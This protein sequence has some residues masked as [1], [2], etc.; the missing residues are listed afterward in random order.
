[1]AQSDSDH[2]V[3]SLDR[4]RPRLRDD[5]RFHFQLA[6]KEPVYVIEDRANRGYH[7][8]G[9]PEYRFLKSLDGRKPAAQLIAESANA[10]GKDAISEQ[11]SENLLRWALDNHLLKSLS[12]SQSDRRI[13]HAEDQAVG[14][15]KK[16]PKLMRFF[17]VKIPMGSPERLIRPFTAVFSWV[18][19]PGAIILWLGLIGYG[20][21]LAAE[22]WTALTASGARALLPAN[23]LW[24]ILITLVLKVFHELAH[25]I[26]TQKFG[27]VVPEWGIQLIALVTPLTYVDATSSW[28]FPSRWKR[29]RVAAAGMYVELGIAVV[30]LH[31]WTRLDPGFLRELAFNTIVVA[32]F[33]TLIFNANPLMRF[34]GYY[35]L[36]DLLNLR[37]VGQR[38]QQAFAWF[39]RRVFL[40]A[41]NQSLPPGIRDRFF[42]YFFYGAAAWCWK[43]LITIGIIAIMTK[44]FHGTGM[45][46]VL[47]SLAI[48][49]AG[50]LTAVWGLFFSKEKSGKVNWPSAAIRI[51]IA[52]GLLAL[53]FFGIKINPSSPA[54]AVIEYPDKTIVRVETSGFLTAIHC[55]DGQRV[56]KGDHLA[57]LEN[58]EEEVQLAKLTTELEHARARADSYFA[59]DRIGEWQT[60]KEVIRGLE[61]KSATLRQRIAAL[62]VVAPVSGVIHAPQ[63]SESEGHFASTGDPILTI[64]PEETPH[65]LI[66]MRQPDFGRLDIEEIDQLEPIQLRI[67]GRTGDLTA[68]VKRFETKAT[69]AIPHPALAATNG[70]PLAVKGIEQSESATL[71]DGLALQASRSESMNYF[72]SINPEANRQSQELVRPRI[73]LYAE[74]P[75][76]ADFRDGEWGFSLVSDAK[77]ERLGLWIYRHFYEFVTRQFAET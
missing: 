43:L 15:K 48:A 32:S 44:L 63:L 59:L 40:G 52:V 68:R 33:V 74:L 70:G 27:G 28:S 55:R 4:A 71:D 18:F 46:L 17:F 21:Y 12:A 57:T 62:E 2:S 30:A 20:A 76:E 53:A 66:S 45:V 26:T 61:E 75:K 10:S 16:K 22:N 77:S 47:L 35:I 39:N 69:R 6:D 54:A 19:S 34:D 58:R 3:F 67:R 13:E 14:M 5:L 7:Q 41:K 37:N 9:V 73:T 11:E 31:F 56:E 23:W 29:M 25:G 50:L 1:M 42:T 24:L 64:L 60:E 49:F 36:S 65:V 51:S 72:E 8:I 38:G